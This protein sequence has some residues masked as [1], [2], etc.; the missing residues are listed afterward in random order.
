MKSAVVLFQI[1][2]SPPNCGSPENRAQT[3]VQEL[4]TIE[5]VSVAYCDANLFSISTALTAPQYYSH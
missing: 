1:D 4:L 5:S 3:T 2:F